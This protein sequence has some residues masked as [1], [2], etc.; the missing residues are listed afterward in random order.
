MQLPAEPFSVDDFAGR[1]DFGVSYTA[2]RVHSLGLR[3]LYGK[4]YD[5]TQTLGA[6]ANRPTQDCQPTI[7]RLVEE[8]HRW[9]QSSPLRGPLVPITE[10]TINRQV[11]LV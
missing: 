11:R 3:K 4:I 6:A 9:Y 2:I 5:E 8:V 1:F 7:D 10:S